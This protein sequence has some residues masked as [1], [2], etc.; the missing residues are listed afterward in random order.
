MT[1]VQQ[2]YDMSILNTGGANVHHHWRAGNEDL[3]NSTLTSKVCLCHSRPALHIQCMEW[4]DGAPI[5]W[6]DMLFP[7]RPLSTIQAQQAMITEDIDRMR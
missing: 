7:I 5:A 6:S 4:F 1:I 2:L 3:A